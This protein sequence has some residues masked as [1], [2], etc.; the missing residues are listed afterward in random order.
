M[1]SGVARCRQL[2]SQTPKFIAAILRQPPRGV[3]GWTSWARW[4]T[5]PFSEDFHGTHAARQGVGRAHGPDAAVR[6]DPAPDRPAPDPRGDYAAGL[7]DAE[8]AEAQGAHAGTHLRHARPY[9]PDGR[10]D[11]SLRGPR[12]GGDGPA[13]VPEHEGVRPAALRHGERHA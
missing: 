13:H 5:I 6:P 11:P 8:G 4:G 3:K 7:S 12:G 2:G 9:H 1:M 10:P